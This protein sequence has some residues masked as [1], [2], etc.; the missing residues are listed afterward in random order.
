MIWWLNSSSTVEDEKVQPI[1]SWMR[2]EM[3]WP[4]DVIEDYLKR[5]EAV[6]KNVSHLRKLTK[7]VCLYVR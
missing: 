1:I 6:G 3:K 5:F 2:N 4:E 7:E